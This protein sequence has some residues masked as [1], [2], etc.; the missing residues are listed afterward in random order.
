MSARNRRIINDDD[1]DDDDAMMIV[2]SHVR[3]PAVRPHCPTLGKLFTDVSCG[4]TS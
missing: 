3:L 4:I 2:R 1:D